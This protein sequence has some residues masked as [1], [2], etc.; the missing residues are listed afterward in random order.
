MTYIFKDFEGVQKWFEVNKSGYALRQITNESERIRSILTSCRRGYLDEGIIDTINN[1][2]QISKSEFENVWHEATHK[3]RLEWDVCKQTYPIGER[4]LGVI[5]HFYPQGAIFDLGD[6]Q[7]CAAHSDIETFR[8]AR[9]FPVRVIDG[10]VKGYDESNM[11]VLV[12][13]CRPYF[14]VMEF[15]I[16]KWLKDSEN[17]WFKGFWCDGVELCENTQHYSKE[18]VR[19]NGYV[20]LNAWIGPCEDTRKEYLYDFKLN[21]GPKALSRYEKDLCILECFSHVCVLDA[22][23]EFIEIQLL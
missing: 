6:I 15:E 11:W 16:C 21:F 12:H 20:N 18:S 8:Y 5:D 3:F 1:C 23:R 14:T 4:V 7:G 9:G 17:E 19:G 2:K 13:E 22:G 10:V